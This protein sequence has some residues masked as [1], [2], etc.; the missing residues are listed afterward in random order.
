MQNIFNPLTVQPPNTPRYVD[1]LGLVLPLTL[2]PIAAFFF[3]K[4]RREFR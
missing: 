4:G 2:L 3:I 1:E